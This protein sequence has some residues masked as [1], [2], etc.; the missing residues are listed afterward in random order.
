MATLCSCPPAD[1]PSI[2]QLTTRLKLAMPLH[3]KLLSSVAEPDARVMSETSD[4]VQRVTKQPM[5]SDTEIKGIF[6]W[7]YLLGV[8]V[9][10]STMADERKLGTLMHRPKAR[11]VRPERLSWTSGH[12]RPGCPLA[13]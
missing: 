8:N 11:L 2:D 13:G 9:I 5:V 10:T 12:T 6:G 1:W 3:A 7:Q 4:H